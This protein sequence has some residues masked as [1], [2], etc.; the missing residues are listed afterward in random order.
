LGLE[1]I[2]SAT[3]NLNVLH[4]FFA[5]PQQKEII[6]PFNPYA[7]TWSA[8]MLKSFLSCKRQFYYKY[9]LKIQNRLD[10]GF[11]EGL[12]LHKLLEKL[13]EEKQDVA[14][15]LGALLDEMLGSCAKARIQK[16]LYFKKIMHFLR[17]QE[18]HHFSQGYTIEFKEKNI[19]GT[20]GGLRF[21]GVIDR[22]DVNVE[23]AMVIDYKSGSTHNA[24]RVKNLEKLDDFQMSIYAFLLKGNYATLKLAFFKILEE[25]PIQYIQALDAKNNLLLEHIEAIKQ[26]T[27]IVA[28]KCEDLAQCIYCPYRLIC[29]RGEYIGK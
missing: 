23:G 5:P 28:D 22:L 7:I 16:E 29:E 27:Q 15:R 24:N 12:M 13:M 8:T 20:I 4:R 18:R 2:Q 17:Y 9:I 3:P 19:D 25:Q 1:K 6:T 26:S 11:N 10:E 14:T 21:K